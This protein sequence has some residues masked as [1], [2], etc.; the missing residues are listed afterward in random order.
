VV[1]NTGIVGYPESLTD[2]SYAGQ[3]LVLTYPLV[4][5]YGVPERPTRR[6]NDLFESDKIQIVALVVSEH[7]V[8]ASHWNGRGTLHGW[9]HSQRIPGLAGV[10]TRALTQ[11]LRTAGAMLGKVVVNENRVAWRN[12]NQENLVAGVSVSQPQCH[13]SGKK[14]VVV[15]DCGCKNNIVRSLLKRGL[16]VTIIP[17]NHPLEREEFDGVVLSNGPG[18]PQMC[19][20]A[21]HNLRWLLTQNKPV[22]GVCLGNQLLALAA[23]ATTYKLKYG[24]RSQNQPCVLVGSKRCFITS[25]NHG[26]AVDE[27]TLGRDWLPWFFNA[28]DGTNEGIRHRTRPFRSVQFH[29]EAWPGPLDTEFLFDEFVQSLA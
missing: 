2:P 16:S 20:D 27:T 11:H 1:F 21:I 18:D 19:Q 6:L 22:F 3:I 25:Q 4:G 15:L 17:W 10:D 24:H 8:Q 12:P 28:N 5:N 7:C 23:G 9:L 14:K 26:Y 13:G 29:P